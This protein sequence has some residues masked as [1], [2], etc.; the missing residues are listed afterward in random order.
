MGSEMLRASLPAYL[1][2]LLEAKAQDSAAATKAPLLRKRD[3]LLD[4]GKPAAGLARTV[5]AYNPWP[6][7]YITIDGV[8]LK[9]LRAHASTTTIPTG[10]RSVVDRGPALG[11]A[12][13]SLV[14]DEV[15][16]AGKKPMPGEDF[17]KGARNWVS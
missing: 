4:L 8:A 12:E 7:A 10:T 15:Q 17:L 2:G 11:T 1:A 13:G 14:L 5:R 16:P 6:G 3:G 9:I